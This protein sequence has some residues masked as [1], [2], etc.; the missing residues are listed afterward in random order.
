MQTFLQKR[1]SKQQ[2]EKS[3]AQNFKFKSGV[4]IG[5]PLNDQTI[6]HPKCLKQQ[7]NHSKQDIERFNHDKYKNF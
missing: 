3:Y 2:K 4:K 5:F 7:A 6:S 1:K